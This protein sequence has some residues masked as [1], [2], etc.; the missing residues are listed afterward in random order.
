LEKWVW[1]LPLM[2]G[3]E[4]AT[5]AMELVAAK[6][7]KVEV[8]LWEALSIKKP[9]GDDEVVNENLAKMNLAEK[10]DELFGGVPGYTA[11]LVQEL[12]QGA[13]LS[14]YLLTL[15]ARVRSIIVKASK[16]GGFSSP[17][18]LATNWLIDLRSPENTWAC[19]RDAGLCGSGPPRGVIF[20]LVLKWLLRHSPKTDELAVL[21]YFRGKFRIDSGMD[22]CLLELEEIVKLKRGVP[23]PAVRLTLSDDKK[24]W[25]QK[26]KEM[27]DNELPVTQ[28]QPAFWSYDGQ[29]VSPGS[30][31]VIMSAEWHVVEV[32]P[33]FPVLDVLLVRR[34]QDGETAK[35]H[36]YLMQIT[37]SPDPFS[38]HF[39]DQTCTEESQKKINAL[40][41]AI[42]HAIS[43][44]A[45]HETSFVMLAPNS[46]V[47]KMVEMDQ[48]AD[49]YFS[50]ASLF[51]NK[52][53]V[54]VKS[55]WSHKKK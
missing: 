11:E 33:G 2:S 39:T 20:S 47:K 1:D 7:G 25:V 36:I 40:V 55:R 37:R 30:E 24:T 5:F 22:G 18:A 17:E 12:C 49:F 46:D 6:H 19:I 53:A 38:K 29:T 4:A 43:K 52:G 42:A 44:D 34:Y 50:P 41:K 10:L 16:E 54:V 9:D 23:L 31:E 32:S 14:S 13:T 26:K 48:M 35:L 28:F 3:D 8:D 27:D 21:L 45:Q 15:S 51:L